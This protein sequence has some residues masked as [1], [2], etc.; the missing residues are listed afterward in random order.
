MTDFLNTEKKIKRFPYRIY[1]FNKKTIS[2][3]VIDN[4]KN[5]IKFCYMIQLNK[6]LMI[7]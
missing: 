6:K 1:D 7:R 3:C 5:K 4:I 2:S